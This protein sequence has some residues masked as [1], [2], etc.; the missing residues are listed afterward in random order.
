MGNRTDAG[1][2]FAAKSHGGDSKKVFIAAQFAGGVGGEGQGEFGIG[3]AVSVVDDADQFEAAFF[4]FDGNLGGPG[5]EGI[6]NQFLDDGSGPLDHF[7]SGDA[8]DQRGGEAFD[9]VARHGG[10]IS[11]WGGKSF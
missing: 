9:G 1:E 2:G 8:I 11:G 10:I 3:D 7:A 4:D 5:V 6:F